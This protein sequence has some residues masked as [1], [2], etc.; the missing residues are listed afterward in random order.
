MVHSFY[1][2]SVPSGENLAVL[3]QA[4]ALEE[5]GHDVKLFSK[6]TDY[7]RLKGFFEL[8]SAFRVTTGFS[9]SDPYDAL[10]DFKPD[11]VHIHN[12]FPNFGHRWL[13]NVKSPI[14]ATVHNYRPICPAGTLV[15]KGEFCTRC[16]ENHFGHSVVNRCYRESALA[17]L[18]LAFSSAS[19]GASAAIER[20]TKVIFLAKRTQ[21]TFQ[22]FSPNLIGKSAIVP[23]F[24]NRSPE[25]SNEKGSHRNGP[26]VF[27]GRLSREK[28]LGDLLTEWPDWVELHVFGDGPEKSRWQQLSAGKPIKFFGEVNHETVLREISAARAVVFP[29]V[30]P[31]NSPLSYLEALSCGTPS[32]ARIGNVVADH[33]EKFSTGIAFAPRPGSIELAL[34]SLHQN[35]S[36]I[37]MNSKKAF[38]TQFTKEVWQA[39]ISKIYESLF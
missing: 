12:L 36:E 19:G 9:P 11:L 38:E 29:S 26:V 18:P 2:S 24:V 28:A 27:V 22:R 10:N 39:E 31:E 35:H 37:S 7:E 8:K 15:R 16:P 30:T 20:A 33:V 23:N 17:T 21:A 25:F 5:M 3:L 13:A 6:N 4:Q 1:S 32:I 34:K 14:V